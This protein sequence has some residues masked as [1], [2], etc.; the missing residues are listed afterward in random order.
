M[1]AALHI[2]HE[3]PA[4]V[5]VCVLHYTHNID[6]L[7]MYPYV[8]CTTHT[9][10]ASRGSNPR[11][12]PFPPS[13]PCVLSVSLPVPSMHSMRIRG[14]KASR[15]NRNCGQDHGKGNRNRENKTQ[16]GGRAQHLKFRW[17]LRAGGSLLL[18]A[19]ALCTL[20]RVLRSAETEDCVRICV[21]A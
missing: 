15:T 8:C 3:F 20:T 11:C 16:T 5:S 13:S 2:Q 9:T 21:V 1:C 7:L 17:R 12:A 4:H 14:A 10:L 18:S 6:T 19:C